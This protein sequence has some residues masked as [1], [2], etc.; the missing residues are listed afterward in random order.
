MKKMLRKTMTSSLVALLSSGLVEGG[1]PGRGGGGFVS[2]PGISSLQSIQTFQNPLYSSGIYSSSFGGRGFVDDPRH[3][4]LCG[5]NP[6]NPLCRE[7]NFPGSRI[8]DAA[9]ILGIEQESVVISGSNSD[10][11]RINIPVEHVSSLYG[12][13]IRLWL[14]NRDK[15]FVVLKEKNGKLEYVGGTLMPISSKGEELGGNYVQFVDDNLNIE[16]FILNDNGKFTSN[17]RIVKVSG[18]KSD[19]QFRRLNYAGTNFYIG[20]IIKDKPTYT[21]TNDFLH[22][23]Y[24]NGNVTMR[25]VKNTLEN[26]LPMTNEQSIRRNGQNEK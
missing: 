12:E 21:L 4:E 6:R 24:D 18:E 14:S 3:T 17:G 8:Q 25:H 1:P 10:D 15:E 9:R 19:S 2:S 13:A 7:V 16:R 5:M 20:E 23:D 22:I 11:N 26:K